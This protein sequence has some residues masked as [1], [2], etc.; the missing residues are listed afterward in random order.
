MRQPDPP[1]DGAAPDRPGPRL[2]VWRL[3]L[4]AA[5]RRLFWR[6]DAP[7][8]A[9]EATVDVADAVRLAAA[10]RLTLKGPLVVELDGP[11][12]PLASPETVLRALAL[13]R[14]HH[15]DILTGVV[16]HG[17]LLGDYA[18]EL[19]ALGVGYVA[20]R[21]D[22]A[23]MATARRLLRGGTCRAEVLTA[24]AAAGLYLDGV[25]GA[26]YVA[27]RA[28]LALAAR[29]TLLP[30][31]NAGEVEALAA[32]AA[33]GGAARVDVV[34]PR[35]AGGHRRGGTPT[36][37]EL[38]EARARAHAAFAAAGGPAPGPG[39]ALL[40]WLE[41][42][43]LKEV[44]R[45]PLEAVDVLRLLP[46]AVE[47]E[48]QP[49]RMLPPRRAQVVAVASRDGVLVDAPLAGVPALRLYAVTDGGIRYL[50]A[51][52]LEESARRRLDGVGDAQRLLRA[53]LGCRTVVATGFSTRA[54]TLLGAVGVRTV[55]AGGA[56]PDVL[57]RV[58][59]GTIRLA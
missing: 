56:V 19:T 18:E 37:G 32:Q 45:A 48:A 31:L 12:D 17:A 8:R 39:R 9:G 15:P 47:A 30:T 4:P 55:A 29:V 53:V 26:L 13:L 24:E 33:R 59:R 3:S 49:G 35:R 16:V 23:R 34:A 5:P 51:R 41:P 14:E 58:A 11:G 21:M 20:L 2:G 1:G 40:E 22:A 28:G 38:A 43:R 50:G 10:A 54:R 6:V 57:D 46:G 42:A 44:E 25:V 52:I 36:R 7:P 27:R